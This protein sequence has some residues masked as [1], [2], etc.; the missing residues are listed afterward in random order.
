MKIYNTKNITDF[1]DTLKEIKSR[2]PNIILSCNPRCIL[3]I[4]SVIF[5]VTNSIPLRSDS[6]LNNRP[7]QLNISYDSL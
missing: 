6:W 7:Q 5:L 3:A 2:L 1:E 4:P